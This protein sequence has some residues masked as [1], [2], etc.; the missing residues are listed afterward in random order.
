MRRFF[1]LIVSI[2]LLS[3]LYSQDKV[4]LDTYWK[5]GLNFESSD[6]SFSVKLGG[7]IQYDVMFINQDDSLSTNFEAENGTEFR[8]ARLYTSGTV[9][10]TVKYK[11]QIDFAGNSVVIKDAY[12]RF[13]KIPFVG[14]ITVG[15][16][17]EPRGFEMI[18]S[19]NFI[20]MM[21]RSL[22]NQFDNDRN[23]GI[24]LNNSF[25]NKRFSVYAGYFFPSGNNAKYSGNKYNLTFRITGLPYYKTDNGF[26]MIH[27][28]G[29]FT[30]EDH[31]N[32]LMSYSSRPEAHLAP[33]YLNVKIDNAANLME[34]NGELV[35]IFNRLSFQSEYTYASVKTSDFS[36]LQE[37]KY[38][39]SSVFGTL[40]W[41]VTGEHK[42]YSK[43]KGAFDRLNPQKNF[44]TKGGF[45]AV[46][47]AVRYS[48]LNL[49]YMDLNGG[50]MDNITFGINWYLNPVTKIVFNYVNSN[51]KDQGVA[52][53]YQM[54]FQITF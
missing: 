21:E 26:K 50:K 37:D 49:N 48:N 42:N 11:F 33:K 25:L 45:G 36:A 47:L 34:I 1:T 4:T 54:R 44:G 23:V 14:N 15:N 30:Y 18:S 19:S 35:L 31:D 43:S 39:F 40:S 41:F 2:F 7:R 3:N 38:A 5:N 17:K 16:F 9:Y 28:G 20:T 12:L 53:I 29:G 32:E 22:A 8:R 27:L 13:T 6:K 51:I 46:E 10:K 24:M 52:N